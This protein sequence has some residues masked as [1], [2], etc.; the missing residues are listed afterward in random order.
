MGPVA[1]ELAFPLFGIKPPKTF[2]REGN[3]EALN[4]LMFGLGSHNGPVLLMTGSRIEGLAM[5]DLCGQ[6][7]TDFDKMEVFSKAWTVFTRSPFGHKSHL[8]LDETESAPAYGRVKVATGTD[9]DGVE[10]LIS[11]M[12]EEARETLGKG[13]INSCI[14]EKDG[15]MW[16]SSR[17]TVWALQNATLKDWIEEIRGPAGRILHAFVEHIPSLLCKGNHPAAEA[18]VQRKRPAGLQ[19]PRYETLACLESNVPLLLVCIGPKTSPYRDLEFRLSW[20]IYELLLAKDMPLW[21]RQGYVAFKYTIKKGITERRACS[22]KDDDR[23]VISSYHLKNVLFWTLEEPSAWQVASSFELFLLLLEKFSGYL[24]PPEKASSICR[25]PLYFLPSCNLLE[26]IQLS[27]LELARA[28][29]KNTLEDPIHAILTSHH[30]HIFAYG[31]GYHTLERMCMDSQERQRLNGSLH[32]AMM[33]VDIQELL[34]STKALQQIYECRYHTIEGMCMDSQERQSLLG[35]IDISMIGSDTQELLSKTQ[36]LLLEMQEQ[37]SRTNALLR[38]GGKFTKEYMHMSNLLV[39]M[40]EYRYAKYMKFHEDD[41]KRQEPGIAVDRGMFVYSQTL[42]ES[43]ITE[44]AN[45]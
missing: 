7:T 3:K 4:M 18:F 29:I 12:E 10:G 26:H 15:H 34:S 43:K 8:V 14:V 27:E 32:F 19:W 23:S 24:E 22:E 20:S 6:S 44:Y 9:E 31:S 5:D 13:K 17:E 11:D 35:S 37:L 21:V 33:G 25:L 41:I 42:L 2:G 45:A 40:D 1:V 39:L 38:I 30:N 16:L 36:Q 28:T